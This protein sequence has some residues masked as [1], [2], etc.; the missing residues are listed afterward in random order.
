MIQLWSDEGAHPEARLV[1]AMAHYN[2]KLS[3]AGVLLAA[4]GLLSSTRGARI[5]MAHGQR[6]VRHGPFEPRALCVGFWIVRVASKQE[7]LEWAQQCPLSDGDVL[8]LRELYGLPDELLPS[9][10]W[11]ELP[12]CELSG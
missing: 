11:A 4:E 10:S 8:E 1:A 2:D 3:R 7:A 12:A 9:E 5:S 6:E